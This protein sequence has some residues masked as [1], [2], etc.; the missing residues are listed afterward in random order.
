[1]LDSDILTSA[2]VDGGSVDITATQFIT[3]DGSGSHI[4]AAA[5]GNGGNIF[6]RGARFV[7]LNDSILTANAIFGNGGQILINSGILL[8]NNSR[9][10]ASSQFGAD[11][12]VRIDALSN[13]SSTAKAKMEDPLDASDQLQPMC[14]AK[15]PGET[16]SFILVGKGGLPVMPGRFLPAHVM[17]DLPEE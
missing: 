7:L 16:G 10:T 17:V 1:M 6:L 5:V 12:E 13:L 11:G 14:T 8:L 9:I 15:I 3:L 4:N 2:G